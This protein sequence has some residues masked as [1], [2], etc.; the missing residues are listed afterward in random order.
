[1]L[2]FIA[3]IEVPATISNNNI[4]ASS[5]LYL[6]FLFYHIIFKS[7]CLE[8]SKSS[9]ALQNKS[10]LLMEISILLLPSLCT[11]IFILLKMNKNYLK[12]LT[13]QKLEVIHQ[14]SIYVQHLQR[15]NV[16]RLINNYLHY[17]ENGFCMLIVTTF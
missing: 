4:P 3:P 11:E 2:T 7:S 14:I 17:F 6:F 5:F 13:S 15:N 10:S 16:V 8:C 9:S 12:D 1:M